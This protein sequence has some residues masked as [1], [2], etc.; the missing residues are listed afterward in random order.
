MKKLLMYITAF[1]LIF[2]MLPMQASAETAEIASG[3]CGDNLTW[4]LT[5]DGTLSISGTGVMTNYTHP[6]KVPWKN[7]RNQVCTVI[8]Q[9]GVTSLGDYAF[10]YLTQLISVTLPE[11]LERIGILA[12]ADTAL[13]HL[14]IPSG[15]TEIGAE[16]FEFNSS[17]TSISVSNDNTAFSS[18]DYGVLFNKDK[19]QLL[20]CPQAYAGAYWIPSTV[21]VVME[22]AFALCKQ[23]TSIEIPGSVKELQRHAF[24]GCSSLKKVILSE[25]LQHIGQEVFSSCGALSGSL[26]IPATVT[27][28]GASPFAMTNLEAIYF[29]G[30]MP[31][32]DSYAFTSVT[33]TAYYLED[34]ATWTPDKIQCCEGTA[35]WKSYIHPCNNGRHVPG[36][37]F[38]DKETGFCGDCGIPCRT[39]GTTV[40]A[41]EEDGTM[42]FYAIG[43]DG[44][45]EMDLYDSNWDEYADQVTA[46]VIEEG[47]T[48]EIYGFGSFVNLK[49][50]SLPDT[51]TGIGRRTFQGCINLEQVNIP[52]NLTH[53]EN[54]AF[55]DCVKLTEVHFPASLEHVSTRTFGG[56]TSLKGIWID[57]KNPYYTN[58]EF[59]VLYSKD[60]T[61]LLQ[62]PGALSS[63]Y[64]IPETV[65]YIE[66]ASFDGCT[67]LTDVTIPN[68]VEML[69]METFKNCTALKSITFP[70][71]IKSIWG[72][73]MFENCAALKTIILEGDAPQIHPY[74]FVSVTATAYYPAAN[75]TWTDDVKQ[76]YGGNITWVAYE[77]EE[78]PD[79]WNQEN[80]KWYYYEN[81]KKL[82]NQW[83]KSGNAWYYLDADGV[84][85]T[86]WEKADDKWYYF[87]ASG[88]MQTGWQKISGKW[89]YLNSEMKTGWQSIG[90]KWYYLN[91]SGVMQTGWVQISGKWYYLNS[92]M[93]TGWQKIDGN[94]YYL[95]S[96]GAMRTGWQKISGKWY[97]LNSEM[98][99]G[100][101]KV[102]GKWYYMDANGAMQ[103]GWVQVSGKWYYMNSSGV[104]QT[105]WIQL[106][107]KWYYLND[108]G[109]M[110]T[111]T[112]TIG[113]KT[114]K[115]NSSGVWVS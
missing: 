82:Q 76:N 81:G 42:I 78:V 94:W 112:Q 24:F 108:S 107:G 67:N 44:T 51:V 105:G 39:S 70:A 59:G 10:Y 20:R 31:E 12:L 37:H 100:W 50:V 93:K 15:V 111:G 1:C 71:S 114:Y 41:I 33:L 92:E 74:C 103:I 68:G 35:T 48:G 6:D 96:D 102:S 36:L 98:K 11:S 7:Y 80:G 47:V 101:Q 34:N 54:N 8:V 22:K 95:A 106:S 73:N 28:I 64:T 5:D 16:A 30:D 52:S 90:G 60:M 58:D 26:T 79:G 32:I 2:Q 91:S 75:D 27:Y 56:C 40:W 113:G 62:A 45:G 29:T 4:V 85:A 109:A 38:I 83:L 53:L 25:G 57:A 88:V 104:M 43:E 99:T 89:Y 110:V 23:L 9:E 115:F 13:C 49:T 72:M 14:H 63:H 3:T 19:T 86:G 21:T 61:Q 55:S 97:Y 18:D 87:S 65:T 17:L 46:L 84:M 66:W 69:D 77:P